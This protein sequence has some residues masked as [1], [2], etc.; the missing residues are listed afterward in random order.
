MSD[1]PNGVEWKGIE[2]NRI[3][4][5]FDALDQV[6]SPV[7]NSDSSSEKGTKSD[8]IVIDGL[9]ANE[10]IAPDSKAE[11]I[12]FMSTRLHSF[13]FNSIQFN[14]FGAPGRP[15]AKVL[16]CLLPD[17]HRH[18]ARRVEAV[19]DPQ[20]PHAVYVGLVVV[21]ETHFVVVNPGDPVQA[22]KVLLF[23]RR[24][25]LDVVEEEEMVD[26]SSTTSQSMQRGAKLGLSVHEATAVW[27]VGFA[28]GAAAAAAA[29]DN[30]DDDDDNDGLA[31]PPFFGFVF[32]FDFPLAAALPVLGLVGYPN[33]SS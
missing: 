17:L 25:N 20:R 12:V 6:S 14:P 22:R 27:M 10:R 16:Q 18:A 2:S 23:V 9:E 8:P 24:A 21:E 32:V 31:I 5:A 7:S 4:F 11:S 29:A 3:E 15:E 1:P 30:D 28:A 13:L 33:Q 26:P 19:D